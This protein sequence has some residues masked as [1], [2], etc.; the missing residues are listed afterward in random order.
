V[1]FAFQTLEFSHFFFVA[2]F[3]S[4]PP[5]ITQL[6]L[7]PSYR[8]P[9]TFTSRTRPYLLVHDLRP[10]VAL[11]NIVPPIPHFTSY[12]ILLISGSSRSF[13][14]FAMFY[15]GRAHW[16]LHSPGSG[17]PPLFVAGARGNTHL[18]KLDP[19][20]FLSLLLVPIRPRTSIVC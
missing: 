8:L 13:F 18:R 9:P 12:L 1:P 11:K 20:F 16:V 10:V 17:A 2:F 15:P 6:L 3:L 4:T 5:L 7:P 19:S 14:A